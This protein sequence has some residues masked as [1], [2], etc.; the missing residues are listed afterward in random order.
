MKRKPLLAV[1]AILLLVIIV[2]APDALAQ[3]QTQQRFDGVLNAFRDQSVRWQGVLISAA[4]WLFFVLAGAQLVWTNGSLALK[5]GDASDFINQNTTKLLGIGIMYVFLVHSFDWSH[6]L[7]KGFLQAGERAV[8]ASAGGAAGAIDPASVFQNGMVVAG[9]LFSQM[10]VWSGLDN[11]SLVICALVMVVCFAFLAAF[12]S[13]VIVESYIVIGGSVLLLGFGGASWTADIAKRTMMYAVSVGAKLFVMQ[14]IVGVAMGSVILWA[15]T[16][17]QDS[18]TSTLALIGLVMLITV[19]AKMVPEL[20]QGILSGTSVGNSGAMLATAA[21]AAAAAVAGT[22]ALK[23]AAGGATGGGT[24]GGGAAAGGGGSS[25][26]GNAQGANTGLFSQQGMHVARMAGH[27][28]ETGSGLNPNSAL[29]PLSGANRPNPTEPEDAGQKPMP[30]SMGGGGDNAG[31]SASPGSLGGDGG[32]IRGAGVDASKSSGAAASAAQTRAPSDAASTRVKGNSPGGGAST[33]SGGSAAG[34]VNADGASPRTTQTEVSGSG[35]DARSLDERSSEGANGTSG[36]AS[37]NL[38]AAQLASGAP[39][40]PGDTSAFGGAAQTLDEHASTAG[41]NEGS[42]ARSL[43]AAASEA[44]TTSAS[45]GAAS[46]A[47]SQGGA[48]TAA[49]RANEAA[50]RAASSADRATSVKNTIGDAP[51]GDRMADAKRGAVAGFLAAGPGGA[52]I[53]AA[54]GAALSPQLDSLRQKA[55]AQLA[56]AK[57]RFGLT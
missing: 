24:G 10:S 6:A 48:S 1:A 55:T 16:Y 12:M 14:L 53:G 15:Q 47:F 42:A 2:Y 27:M 54:A 38:A 7:V 29:G 8:L 22:A 9:S 21:A 30:P 5:G 31:S 32:I 57:A 13:V 50:D 18:S 43:D 45:S 23:P 37:G 49:D 51:S 56:A 44:P 26:A 25:G 11:L 52:V 28:V 39:A 40:S 46:A 3:D 17:Q 36:A 41:Q 19:A 35:G 4:R 34:T 33:E 20:V